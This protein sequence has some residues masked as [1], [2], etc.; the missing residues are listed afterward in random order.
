MPP[1]RQEIVVVY[2]GDGAKKARDDMRG[3]SDEGKKTGAALDGL[4]K[5]GGALGRVFGSIG[6][7]VKGAALQ[8]AAWAVS[9]AAVRAILDKTIGASV[10]FEKSLGGV[11]KTAELSGTELD[12]FGDDV[13]ALS[14]RLGIAREELLQI[15]EAGGQLGIRGSR[16]LLAFTESVSKLSQVTELSAEQA[17]ERIA[18]IA[19]AFGVPIQQAENLGSVLNALS[20]V[21]SAKAGEIADGLQLVG[22]AGRSLGL[23]V[24]QVAALQATLIGAGVESRTA[25]TNLRNIFGIVLDEAD[26]VSKTLGVTR[27]EF[28][29]LI[30]DDAFGTLRQYLDVLRE[31]PPALR[32]IAIFDTFGRENA[33]AVSALVGQTEQLNEALRVSTRE[34]REATSL[35]NE[36]AASVDNVTSKFERVMNRMGN[37]AVQLGQRIAEALD[38]EGIIDALD[39]LTRAE[40]LTPRQNLVESLKATGFKPEVVARIELRVERD[41]LRGIRDEVQKFL[42]DEG[43]IT[44]PTA[45]VPDPSLGQRVRGAL[46]EGRGRIQTETIDVSDLSDA[47]L[48]K[49]L[50]RTREL[51]I[52]FQDAFFDAAEGAEASARSTFAINVEN[53]VE[54]LQETL[55]KREELKA[56]TEGLTEAEQKLRDSQRAPTGATQETA[57]AAADLL[58]KTQE[59]VE[60]TAEEAKQL[61]RARDALQAIAEAQQL[62]GTLG[63]KEREALEKVFALREELAKVDE[64]ALTLGQ[65]AVKAQREEV[66]QRLRVAEMALEKATAFREQIQ[67]AAAALGRVALQGF[68]SAV[69]DSLFE[70]ADRAITDIL[71]DIDGVAR[72]SSDALRKVGEGAIRE[73]DKIRK[74]SEEDLKRF[75]ESIRRRYDDV[76]GVVRETGRLLDVFGDLSEEARRFVDGLARG[77]E[78]IGR[79]QALQASGASTLE[80][81][82]VGIGAFTSLYGGLKGLFDGI[83]A[84]LNDDN[85]EMREA[86]RRLQDALQANV[87]AIQRNTEAL[88]QEAQVG[89][90][91]SPE[92]VEA[93]R[94]LIGGFTEA[95]AGALGSARGRVLPGGATARAFETLLQQLA[96]L[97][98]DGLEIGLLQEAFQSAQ[99]AGVDLRGVIR[100]LLLDLDAGLAGLGGELGQ[101]SDTLGGSIEALGFFSRFI[102]DDVPAQ[103]RFFVEKLLEIED[104]PAAVREALQEVQG[105]DLTS[106]AG[107]DRLKA[108]IGGLA[109]ALAS[110]NLPL[111][112]FTPNDLTA[113]LD[114]LSRFSDPGLI[115]AVDENG[116]PIGGDSP[117]IGQFAVGRITIVEAERMTALLDTI[118]YRAEQTLDVQRQQLTVQQNIQDILASI[119]GAVGTAFDPVK[120]IPTPI[121]PGD[122]GRGGDRIYNVTVPLNVDRP[123]EFTDQDIRAISEGLAQELYHKS[124]GPYPYAFGRPTRGF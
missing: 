10:A 95:N 35:T 65:D 86:Q 47:E 119:T 77:I 33:S 63:T 74:K 107:Q 61:E 53:A 48:R 93:A 90:N 34:F 111:G 58:D 2:R 38:L 106:Q 45:F 109:E 73:T 49:K 3:L 55:D 12:S 60:L 72:I 78:G 71:E 97:D 113:L 96:E 17:A 85:R 4:G 66:E 94:G 68:D 5:K 42:R 62:R 91:V 102:S 120:G 18:K 76:A 69:P 99:A 36:F 9:I 115:P 13:L 39:D 108:I 26:K 124:L 8:F 20:N 112:A 32:Q 22:T 101:F 43:K 75:A 87:R 54:Q 64:A 44:V 118:R 27:Q 19:I 81:L 29:S 123:G 37:S 24:E 67:T 25:G 31:M 82:P 40:L 46:S 98:I 80:Q 1:L 103:L 11:R 51:L 117:S 23:T 79:L 56:V 100:K 83:A 122:I 110:G 114:A 21:T 104:L 89:A 57:E 88:L 7:S 121:N 41:N 105:L 52:T 50:D 14:N 6:Q 30:E 70:K 59:T 15:A 16:N 28:L 92:Q 84:T 116:N